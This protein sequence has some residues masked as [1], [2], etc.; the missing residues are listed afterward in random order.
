MKVYASLYHIAV[1]TIAFMSVLLIMFLNGV[2]NNVIIAIS[3][4]FLAILILTILSYKGKIP[5]FIIKE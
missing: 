3:F 1:V 4:V 2:P 5:L